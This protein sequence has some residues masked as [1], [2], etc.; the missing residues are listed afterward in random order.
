VYICVTFAVV[1]V[2]TCAVVTAHFVALTRV[3]VAHLYRSGLRSFGM[4]ST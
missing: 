4:P 2:L 3:Q 1:A